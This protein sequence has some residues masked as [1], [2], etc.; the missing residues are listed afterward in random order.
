MR[1]PKRTSRSCATNVAT[2]LDGD[3][4]AEPL[5]KS[6]SASGRMVTK[7]APKTEPIMLPNPPR[8]TIER[9]SMDTVMVNIS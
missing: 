6:C 7:T 2:S 4:V 9:Y 1:L 8:M 5:R 3:E